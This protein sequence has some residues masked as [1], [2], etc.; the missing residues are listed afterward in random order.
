[1]A[2]LVRAKEDLD[3]VVILGVDILQPVASATSGHTAAHVQHA[4]VTED[5]HV[6]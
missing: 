1:M 2:V 3:A 4:A 6:M 5:V